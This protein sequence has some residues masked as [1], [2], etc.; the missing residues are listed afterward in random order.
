MSFKDFIERFSKKTDFYTTSVGLGSA[1]G[2]L[3][4][5]QYFKSQGTHPIVIVAFAVYG[6]YI[7]IKTLSIKEN[8]V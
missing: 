1:G 2:M 7:V 3:A 6:L 4:M 8:H 5:T